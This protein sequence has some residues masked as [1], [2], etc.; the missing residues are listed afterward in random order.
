[1]DFSSLNASKEKLKGNSFG[2]MAYEGVKNKGYSMGLN[3]FLGTA[4]ALL[5]PILM[6]LINFFKADTDLLFLKRLKDVKSTAF[7]SNGCKLKVMKE[8]AVLKH[9]RSKIETVR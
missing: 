1:M 3:S 9:T 5:L 2:K 4:G 8:E 6:K 7:R